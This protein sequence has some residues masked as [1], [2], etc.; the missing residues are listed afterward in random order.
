MENLNQKQLHDEKKVPIL[1]ETARRLLTHNIHIEE[2]DVSPQSVRIGKTLRELDFRGRLGLNIVSIIRGNR[3]INIP[4]ADERIY[5]YDK[6]IV[7]GSDEDIQNLMKELDAINQAQCL[8]ED[9]QVHVS[10]APFEVEEGSPMIGHSLRDLNIQQN[11]ECMVI[12]VERGEDNILP[13]AGFVL[14][15]GDTLLLAGEADKLSSF[16]TNILKAF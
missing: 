16:G 3:K 15:K 10:L 7:A 2:I 9:A 14:M 12:T 1:P 6:L 11:T 4:E 13:P 5:P 8:E